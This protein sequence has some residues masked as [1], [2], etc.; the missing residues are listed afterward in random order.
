[1]PENISFVSE[2]VTL[3]GDLYRAAAS[4]ARPAPIIVMAPGFGG[5]LVHSITRFAQRFAEHGFNV[6][7]YD[8]RG[9][10]R[11]D[12]QPRQEADPV[13]Q[14]RAYRDAITFC[15]T[16]DGVDAS[17]IGLWGSSYSG[18]HVIEVAAID[19]RV[20][21]I[22]AQVPT[23]SGFAQGIRRTA[24]AAVPALLARFADDRKARYLGAPP[25]TLPM[26]SDDPAQACAS[27]GPEAFEYYSVPGFV[28]EITLRS[29]EMSRE[30]EPGI[31]IERVSP[32][33]ML[34]IVANADTVTPADLSLSAY[35]RALEP[36]RLVMIEGG[37]FTPYKQHFETTSG[38][39]ISWFTEHLKP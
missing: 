1:M 35:N 32:T 20:K 29:L 3:R 27:P 11:S 17:R 6:L 8:N 7:A 10:G 16:L 33:P 37:H 15:Q 2:G 34:M 13:M 22:V 31:Y 39:A 4:P 38:A 23:I 19:R 9:F 12:G 14:R 30:N 36:K 28:N 18:G 24:P 25:V 21:C 26:V 5:L